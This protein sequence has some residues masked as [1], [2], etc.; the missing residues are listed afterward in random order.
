[1]IRTKIIATMGPAC[2]DAQTLFR[3]FEAGVDVCRL[4]FSHGTL[5]QHLLMLRTIREA[6]ARFD[7]PIAI[8]GDLCGPKIR[9]GK[10]ADHAQSGG[11]PIAVGDE[12]IIQRQP[13]V[14]EA[15]RVSCTYPNL[16]DDV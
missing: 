4:N 8:L 2:G 14:G 13:I 5:E 16:V 12:L 6:A 11:M 3:L 7:Q 10:V 1:M 9:L 15:G